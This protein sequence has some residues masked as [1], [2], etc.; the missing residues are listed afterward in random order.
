MII[1]WCSFYLR[2]LKC[3]AQKY[4]NE[5]GQ[6]TTVD[7]I[8]AIIIKATKF[9]INLGKRK[10]NL[11]MREQFFMRN[12]LYGKTVLGCW[13]AA[14]PVLLNAHIW[15]HFEVVDNNIP[16]Y[17]DAQHDALANAR[18]QLWQRG[19]II[20]GDCRLICVE[21]KWEFIAAFLFALIR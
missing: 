4:N 3:K 8:F 17:F 2:Q 5:Q 10:F 9:G 12:S 18:F 11:Y 6:K 15:Q 16:K 13:L 7:K 14:C 21:I 1:K 20:I 19:H